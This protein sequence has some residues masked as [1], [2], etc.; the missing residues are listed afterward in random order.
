MG[1]CASSELDKAAKQQTKFKEMWQSRTCKTC[2]LD[3]NQSLGAFAGDPNFCN[4][5]WHN[6]GR[7]ADCDI[8]GTTEDC[9]NEDRP[10]G[11]LICN[12]CHH[13]TWELRNKPSVQ[14]SVGFQSTQHRSHI[15]DKGWST[16]LDNQVRELRRAQGRLDVDAT[17][18]CEQERRAWDVPPSADSACNAPSDAPPAWNADRQFPPQFQA[19]PSCPPMPEK[20]APSAPVYPG[21]G[22]RLAVGVATSDATATESVFSVE[23]GLALLFIALM[24]LIYAFFT[25]RL[26][27]RGFKQRDFIIKIP[28]ARSKPKIQV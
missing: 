25:Y 18:V 4:N 28:T 23:Q 19:R 15:S 5:K 8:Y 12:R 16:G 10:S 20:G 14:T 3:V 24:F 7:C 22:R 1:L 13:P 26:R 6:L 9:A 17:Y 2:D 11:N 27:C 21:F